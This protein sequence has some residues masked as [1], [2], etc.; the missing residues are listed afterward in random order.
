MTMCD[1]QMEIAAYRR[2]QDLSEL[3]RKAK[4]AARRDRIY[5]MEQIDFAFAAAM[6]YIAD[7]NWEDAITDGEL[8]APGGKDG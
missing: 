8:V 4:K 2:L 7:I 6:S 5:T 3:E 1:R